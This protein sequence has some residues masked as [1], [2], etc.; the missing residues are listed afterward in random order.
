MILS[1]TIAEMVRVSPDRLA[2]GTW[3]HR[4]NRQTGQGDIRA[5]YSADFIALEG[6]VRKPFPL[7]GWMCVM[8]ASRGTRD[9]CT[10][11]AWYR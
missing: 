5:S 4:V 8:T 6:R 7:H 10:Y 11:A 3:C 2:S 1:P 9:D